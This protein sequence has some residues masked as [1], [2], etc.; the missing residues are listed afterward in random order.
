MQVALALYPGVSADECEAFTCV[1]DQLEGAQLVG[2]GA[3]VG[4]IEGPGGGHRIDAVFADVQQPDVVLVP[5]GIGCAR[6]ARDEPLLDWLRSVAPRCDWMAAS[7]TGTVIVAGAGLLGN[8]AA[9]THWLA[10]DLLTEH[11]SQPSEDRV[12]EIGNV[13]TCEGRITAMHVALLVTLRVAGPRAVS[14]VR[15]RL[16][17]ASSPQREV[18]R[19]RRWWDEFRSRRRSTGPGRPRNRELDAPD[20][21]EFRPLITHDRPPR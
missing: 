15:E 16:A 8:H 21:I 14:R 13:I 6:A 2:V 19:W 12:V 4:T 20:V 1:F 7:S 5:G 18:P 17:S 10:G 11:G 9:A 3:R